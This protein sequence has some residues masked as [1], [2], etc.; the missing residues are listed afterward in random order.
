VNL[1]LKYV[2]TGGLVVTA[3]SCLAQAQSLNV[4]DDWVL[5]CDNLR[6]CVAIGMEPEGNASGVYLRVLRSGKGAAEPDIKITAYSGGRGPHRL[7]LSFDDPS[8]PALGELAA[9]STKASESI[10]AR[11]PPEGVRLFV[12]ALGKAKTLSVIVVQGSDASQPAVISLSGATAA[13]IAMDKQQKRSGTTTALISPGHGPAARVPAPPTL[14][15]VRAGKP[16]KRPPPTTM[17]KPVAAAVE[18][19]DC[20]EPPET[21]PIRAWLNERTLFWGVL[22]TKGAYRETYAFFIHRSGAP[23]ARPMKFQMPGLPPSDEGDNLLTGPTFDPRRMT[24]DFHDLGRSVGDCGTA[25]R[26]VWDG[27]T[28]QPVE[29]RSMP[30]CRGV[31]PDA[32]PVTWRAGVR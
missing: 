3:S 30:H 2:A 20:D 19:A 15:V 10:E 12:N 32:W 8:L 11:L 21:R 25:G 16:T 18:R 14:P 23:T 6:Q 17:P 22:C 1:L 13:L 29:L 26:F 24:L 28:F 7:R 5:G 9:S 4:F 31:S 27:G